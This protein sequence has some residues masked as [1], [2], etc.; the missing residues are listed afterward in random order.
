MNEN[1]SVQKTVPCKTCGGTGLTGTQRRHTCKLCHGSGTV[2]IILIPVRI[3][4]NGE[5]RE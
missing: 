4:Q 1:C 2:E 3:S 5:G